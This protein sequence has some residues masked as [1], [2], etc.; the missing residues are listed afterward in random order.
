MVKSYYLVSKPLQYFNVTNIDDEIKHKICLIVDA[1]FNAKK[2]YRNVKNQDYWNKVVFFP[3]S[4][5][6][7]KWLK[8]N[9]SHIDYVYLDSDYG[10]KKTLWLR[11]INTKNIFVYEEG[12]GSYRNDLITAT[13]TNFLVIFFLKL[14]GIKEYMGGGRYTKGI[15][16]YDLKKH[17][18]MI[19]EYNKI[20]KSFKSGFMQHVPYIRHHFLYQINEEL[21]KAISHKKILLYLTSRNYNNKVDLIINQYPKHYKI[22]KPHPRIKTEFVKTDFDYILSNDVFVEIFILNA[23]KVCKEI[24]IL[25]E[26]SS[27]LQYI[28]SG[29]IKSIL[30]KN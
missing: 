29:N 3:N 30:L 5:E 17:E 26:N 2:F 14:I 21:L 12:T 19:P 7:Y 9:V 16:V 20:R 23:I 4:Y 8:D 10:L 6:A 15:V 1:F 28:E 27:S 18:Q 22:I 25:H 13:H 11:R 24:K